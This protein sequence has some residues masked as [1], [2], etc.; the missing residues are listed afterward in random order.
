MNGL[1]VRRCTRNDYEEFLVTINTA[2]GKDDEWFQRNWGGCTPYPSMATDDE[3]ALHL[4][5]EIDGKIAGGLGCYPKDLC[6]MNR[7]GERGKISAYGIGQVSCLP[8]YRNRGVMTAV[9]KKSEQDMLEAGAVLG[10]LG[11]DRWRYGHFG[12][13]F[14]GN[15]VSYEL[16]EWR[17]KKLLGLPDNAAGNLTVRDAVPSDCDEI[18]AAYRSLPAYAVRDRRAWTRLFNRTL[19]S[20]DECGRYY[21]HIGEKDGKKAYLCFQPPNKIAEAYGDADTLAAMVLCFMKEKD[22][23]V[24]ELHYPMM[25]GEP[26]PITRMLFKGASHMQNHVGHLFSIINAKGLLEQAADILPGHMP[27]GAPDWRGLCGNDADLLARRLTRYMYRPSGEADSFPW[28]M[29]VAP[30]SIWVPS[31]DDI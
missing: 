7:V 30:L 11:G 23:S 18:D 14:G 9:L 8:E 2:F 16:H 6:I 22:R 19:P 20:S 12:Y 5:C 15:R 3:I 4:I 25:P 1:S 31:A 10:F 24:L 17:F 26:D 21:W 13:D 27:H 28:L 29:C